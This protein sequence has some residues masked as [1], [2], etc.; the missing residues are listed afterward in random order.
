[1]TGGAGASTSAVAPQA[2][3]VAALQVLHVA[4]YTTRNWTLDNRVSRAQINDL[5]EALHEV[6]SLLCRWHEGAQREL[7]M[8]FDEY[9]Q[10]WPEPQ[11]R[12][13]FDQ[14]LLQPRE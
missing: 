9:D 12:A 5:W 7:E 10:K 2:A 6:P 8:Y 11:L 14:A 3:L 1:M 13:I 4:G